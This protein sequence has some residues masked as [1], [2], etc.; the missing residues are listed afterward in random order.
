MQRVVFNT[1]FSQ[2]HPV[3]FVFREFE[4]DL[5][6]TVPISLINHLDF[7]ERNSPRQLE[8]VSNCRQLPKFQ[9]IKFNK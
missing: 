5:L 7:L 3:I 2:S 4:I 6:D 9:A 1:E 8:G